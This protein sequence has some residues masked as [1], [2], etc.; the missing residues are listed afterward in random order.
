MKRPLKA[1]FNQK[2]EVNQ[3]KQPELTQFQKDQLYQ[4]IDQLE[5]KID[6]FI[7]NAQKQG[8]EGN[9][10]ESEAIMI[11]VEKHRA[12]KKDLEAILSGEQPGGANP[13]EG[14]GDEA[15]GQDGGPDNLDMQA[16]A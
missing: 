15:Q 6:F 3:P 2:S 10:E 7:T 11:E 1:E 8:E 16:A 4:R 9:I 14:A 5:Q 12:Q 13:N